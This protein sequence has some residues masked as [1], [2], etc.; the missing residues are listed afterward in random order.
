MTARS[1][2]S[3]RFGVPPGLTD[4][5]VDVLAVL[6]DAPHG[7]AEA[8]IALLPYGSRTS[9]VA[10][11]VIERMDGGSGEAVAIC[12]TDRGWS[13][14]AACARARHQAPRAAASGRPQLMPRVR[15]FV[16]ALQHHNPTV[17]L[18]GL[19]ARLHREH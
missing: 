13:V 5:L 9:L 1:G 7:L 8:T 4:E 15:E 6:D 16:Q 11:D 3:N 10:H 12:I 2:A 14:I 17:D 18:N 19:S